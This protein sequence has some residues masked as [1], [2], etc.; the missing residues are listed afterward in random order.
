MLL[1]FRDLSNDDDVVSHLPLFDKFK[2]N[3]MKDIRNYQFQSINH[4]FNNNF[5][6]TM[7]MDIN[8]KLKKS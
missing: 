3:E 1:V 6:E 8:I 5:I 4:D 2:L 7:H